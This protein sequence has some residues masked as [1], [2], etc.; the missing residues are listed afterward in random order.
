MLTL[1][2]LLA[3]EMKPRTLCA[4]QSVAVLISVKVAPL[5]RP[6][7]A[8]IFAPLLSACGVAACLACVGLAAF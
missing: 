7:S 8:R 6:I 4:C 3:V 1:C 2:F 5:G